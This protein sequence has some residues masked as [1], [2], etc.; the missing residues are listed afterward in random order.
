MTK[1]NEPPSVYDVEG[2]RNLI[3]KA[4]KHTASFFSE[5]ALMRLGIANAV[6]ANADF[7]VYQRVAE[8]Y[9]IEVDA[10][11]VRHKFGRRRIN[12]AKIAGILTYVLT[13]DGVDDFF[14]INDAARAKGYE[15]FCS[16]HV[17]YHLVTSI[18]AC[19]E[20]PREFRE[21]FGVCVLKYTADPEWLS[22]GKH[23]L[24][25]GFGDLDV[26]LED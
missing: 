12:N 16:A 23:G 15:L 25:L 19:R 5:R 2:R 3:E 17:V 13:R 10:Y 8:A 9:F 1:S 20:L 4:A 22:L 7:N 21:E 6:Q 18:L 14:I 24:R 26:E 11:K